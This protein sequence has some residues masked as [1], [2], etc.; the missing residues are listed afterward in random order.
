MRRILLLI[1]LSSLAFAPLPARKPKADPNA[2][3]LKELQGEWVVTSRNRGPVDGLTAVIK[4]DRMTFLLNGEVRTE[5]VIVLDVTKDP[6]VF[7][8]KP[9]KSFVTSRDLPGIYRLDG[10]TL[11]T[12]YTTGAGGGDRPKGFDGAGRTEQLNVF[13]RKKP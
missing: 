3:A 13:R 5:W 12:S 7:D 1:A 10:D 11:T 6:R 9:V 8:R 2:Q 4:G